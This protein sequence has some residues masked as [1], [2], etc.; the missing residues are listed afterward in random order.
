MTAAENIPHLSAR[1]AGVM[2][3][4]AGIDRLVLTHQ[5]PGETAARHEAEAG[6]AFG[7]PVA[8]SRIGDRFT[9]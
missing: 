7:A 9:V 3:R 8:A 5:M 1:Q 4:E 6:A 2:A